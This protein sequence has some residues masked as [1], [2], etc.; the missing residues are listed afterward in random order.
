MHTLQLLL[1]GTAVIYY[2]DEIGLKDAPVPSFNL[3]Q[4]PV[5]IAAGEVNIWTKISTSLKS[6]QSIHN[7]LELMKVSEVVEKPKFEPQ[8]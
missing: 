1:P 6:C 5:G 8:V 7:S 3:T 4:D 2:G